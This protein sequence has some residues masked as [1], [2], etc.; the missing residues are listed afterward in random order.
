[1]V[2]LRVLLEVPPEKKKRKKKRKRKRK[3]KKKRKEKEK[4]EKFGHFIPHPLF[5]SQSAGSVDLT[6]FLLASRRATLHDF[7]AL[8]YG[9][10]RGLA[11]DRRRGFRAWVGRDD[12]HRRNFCLVRCSA[13]KRVQALP[14][15]PLH[16]VNTVD[17][18][19]QERVKSRKN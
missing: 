19:L 7:M 18:P 5:S 3:R 13:H 11:Y 15:M 10:A 16:A 2:D 4:K 17:A 8:S 6:E 9:P 14:T 1:M 12:R